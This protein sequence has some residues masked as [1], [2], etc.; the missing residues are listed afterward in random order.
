MTKRYM[1]IDENQEIAEIQ[2]IK[3]DQ[4]DFTLNCR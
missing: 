3:A 2:S 1:Y 4:N